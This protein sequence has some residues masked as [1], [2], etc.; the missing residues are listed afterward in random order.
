MFFNSLKILLY[1]LHGRLLPSGLDNKYIFSTQFSHLIGFENLSST[2]QINFINMENYIDINKKTWNSKVEVHVDSDFYNNEH[3]LRGQNTVPFTDL[4]ALGDIKGKSILHLQCH[5]GQDTL[6]L[7]RLGAHVTGVDFSDKAIEA[8]KKLNKQLGL[9]AHFICCDVY[10]TLN[11]ITEQFDIVYTSYGTIGWLPDLDLW[12]A[13]ISKALKPGGKF[14]FFEFHPVVWMFD[15]DFT[16]VQYNYFKSK[17]I[18]EEETGTYADK[19]AEISNSTI[20]WN[21]SLSEVFQ[22]LLKQNMLID[23]F[24]E[25]DYSHYACFNNT[26]EFEPNKFRISTFENKIPMMYGVIATQS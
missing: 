16:H 19:N 18:V 21:H 13:V 17:P 8:A 7:A 15:N 23:W 20:S 10:E 25:Y 1:A 12:A 3:F 5:F 26:F 14:V 2:N 9:N 22:A 11:H 4:E 24:E 6:S